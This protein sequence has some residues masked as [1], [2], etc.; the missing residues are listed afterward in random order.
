MGKDNNLVFVISLLIFIAVGAL[1]FYMYFKKESFR[2]FFWHDTSTSKN[3]S[4]DVRGDPLRISPKNTG[5]FYHSSY[6]YDNHTNQR[7]PRVA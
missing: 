7:L 3:S 4:Y 2:L 5:A 1:G 6:A